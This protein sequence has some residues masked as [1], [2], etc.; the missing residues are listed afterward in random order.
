MERRAP[1]FLLSGCCAYGDH[2]TSYV[3]FKFLASCERNMLPT[4]TLHR[5]Q[6][7]V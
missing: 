3:E 1:H 5:R 6:D 4:D 2:T 7:V